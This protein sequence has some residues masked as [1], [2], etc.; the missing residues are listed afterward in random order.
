[1]MPAYHFRTFHTLR[2]ISRT[3]RTLSFPTTALSR[4][5]NTYPSSIYLFI[6]HP[7]SIP[8]HQTHRPKHRIALAP[9]KEAQDQ[10]CVKPMCVHHSSTRREQRIKLFNRAMP[11]VPSRELT[12]VAENTRGP[13]L[14]TL[15][16]FGWA[17][18]EAFLFILCVIHEADEALSF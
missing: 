16:I 6:H 14:E 12:E 4:H 1:M 8:H 3:S 17:G 11:R 15:S 2:G 18:H 9:K 5:L 10:W 13:S 7:T